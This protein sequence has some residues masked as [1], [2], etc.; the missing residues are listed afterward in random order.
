LTTLFCLFFVFVFVVLKKINEFFFYFLLIENKYHIMGRL[1][2]TQVLFAQIR[3]DNERRQ[4]EDRERQEREERQA[5]EEREQAERRENERRD[6]IRRKKEAYE[7]D[8]VIKKLRGIQTGLKLENGFFGQHM[9]NQEMS[10]RFIEPTDVVLELGGNI[11]RNSLVISSLLSDSQN[12]VVLESD[13]KIAKTLEKN[14]DNNNFKFVIEAKALSKQPLIQRGWWTKPLPE[15]EVP[16][17]WTPVDIVDF[18]TLQSTTGLTFNTLVADSEGSLY[19]SLKEDPSILDGLEKVLLEND[20][21]AAR[22]QQDEVRQILTSK[23]FTVV[24]DRESGLSRPSFWQVWTKP[25]PEVT[26]VTVTVETTVVEDEPESE[27][28]STESV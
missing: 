6:A 15:G 1:R 20:Y 9:V 4:R 18:E 7:N 14:R 24:F 28:A 25:K 23:G 26:P 13:A 11:G 8:P 27:S 5:R 22:S 12:L 2:R 21:W 3:G 19:Y 16:K 10:V 17:Y